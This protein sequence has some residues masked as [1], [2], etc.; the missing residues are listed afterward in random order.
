MNQ[1]TREFFTVTQAAE[2]LGVSR[3]TVHRWVRSG[4]LRGI[5]AGNF[6]LLSPSEVKAEVAKRERNEFASVMEGI[7][8]RRRKG[9]NVSIS[10]AGDEGR[11]HMEMRGPKGECLKAQVQVVEQ[12]GV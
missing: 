9:W 3:M 2:L 12:I 5:K 4:R 6:L 7:V 8:A 1:A 11:Y 10:H